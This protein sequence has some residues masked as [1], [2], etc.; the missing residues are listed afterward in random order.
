MTN[1]DG[2]VT[3][4]V[5]VVLLVVGVFASLLFWATRTKQR[6]MAWAMRVS[7]A[8]YFPLLSVFIKRHRGG[9]AGETFGDTTVAGFGYHPTF[10][11]LSFQVLAPEAV[12]AFRTF[13]SL[14]RAW[15]KGLHGALNG[16]FAFFAVRAC[17]LCGR[18][19][20]HTVMVK[21]VGTVVVINLHVEERE[22]GKPE[23][24]F[25]SFHSILGLAGKPP[26]LERIAL[27]LCVANTRVPQLCSARHGLG[28]GGRWPARVSVRQVAGHQGFVSSHASF[29]GVLCLCH[30]LADLAARFS[31]VLGS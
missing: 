17:A 16:C 15:Q 13:A 21:V 20:T 28:P 30:G 5:S 3:A 14:P 27:F 31:H 18:I 19:L 25:A 10:L 4:I 7:Y 23:S 2:H 8:A 11:A 1:D 6:V 22:D 26:K 29:H 12:L 24:H 9:W